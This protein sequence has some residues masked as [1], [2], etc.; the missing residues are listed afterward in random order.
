MYTRLSLLHF[1]KNVRKRYLIK[2]L[3]YIF[4]NR[5]TETWKYLSPKV[6]GGTSSY[7]AHGVQK[8]LY[9]QIK[10]HSWRL[11]QCQFVSLLLDH[12]KQLE[13]QYFRDKYFNIIMF[14][15]PAYLT[16]SASGEW[17]YQRFRNR[18]TSILS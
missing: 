12:V 15:Q 4:V 6:D 14:L 13:L 2:K 16:C 10:F 7:A 1:C 9:Q 18:L 5:Q 11:E 8:Y 17:Y 3:L